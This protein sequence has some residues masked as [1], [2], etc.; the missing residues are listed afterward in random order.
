MVGAKKKRRRQNLP[1]P[2]S[3]DVVIFIV[4]TIIVLW[5]HDGGRGQ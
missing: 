4:G 1:A 3:R 2:A 5:Y